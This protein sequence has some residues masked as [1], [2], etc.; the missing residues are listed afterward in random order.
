MKLIK[1]FEMEANLA[2]PEDI[3]RGFGLAFIIPTL[4]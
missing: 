3:F 2:A 1:I 4:L